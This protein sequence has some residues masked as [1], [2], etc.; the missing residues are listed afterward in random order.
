[1]APIYGVPAPDSGFVQLTLGADAARAGIL[2]QAAVVA[3]HSPPDRTSPT[4]RGVFISQNLLCETPPSPPNIVPTFP[5]VDPDM[6]TRQRLEQA[7][8]GAACAACHVLFDPLGFGLEHLDAIGQYRATEDGLTIDATGSLDGVAFDGAVELGA[9]LRQNPRALACLLSNF[10]RDANGRADA[11]ADSE[12]IDSL[13]QTLAAKD[14]VWRDLV[15]EF[16][17]SEAFRSAPATGGDQ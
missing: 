15:A 6:T 12:Q 3:G 2:G 13:G 10:Y 17:T 1:L 11:A 16:V 5:P 14:Y 4:Y 7:T 9:A 8:S